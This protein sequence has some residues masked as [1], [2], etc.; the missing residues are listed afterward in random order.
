MRRGTTIVVAKLIIIIDENDQGFSKSFFASLDLEILVGVYSLAAHYQIPELMTALVANVAVKKIPLP[1]IASCI[2]LAYKCRFTRLSPLL[3]P[4]IERTIQGIPGKVRIMRILP[5]GTDLDGLLDTYKK[6]LALKVW[7]FSC[8]LVC[9]NSN[10]KSKVICGDT[11]VPQK[12]SPSALVD[13]VVFFKHF[14][15]HSS[16]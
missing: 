8:Q 4:L 7:V 6:F 1:D 11:G 13:Q 10:N 16:S 2:T 15:K 3:S 5:T 14:F 12:F 9:S